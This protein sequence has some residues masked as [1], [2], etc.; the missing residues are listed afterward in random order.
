MMT[1][2]AR[3]ARP[4]IWPPTRRVSSG[5]DA[6]TSATRMGTC[7]GDD[8]DGDSDG[9]GVTCGKARLGSPTGFGSAGSPA[10][11]NSP[12]DG[13]AGGGNTPVP[14]GVFVPAGVF[15][16]VGFALTRT[17][18]DP[19]AEAFDCGEVPV[20]VRVTRVPAAFFGTAIAARNW[21]GREARAIEHTLPPGRE[22][23]VKL[24]AGLA[25]FA[26]MVIFAVPLERPASQTQTA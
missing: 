14:T 15:E 18:A 21:T 13:L 20:A 4:M 22:Q 3:T 7:A 11:P 16:G 23:T 12:A 1:A 25:G 17:L 8:D 2:A 9:E 6:D 5:K 26:V 19:D 10:D 24:G